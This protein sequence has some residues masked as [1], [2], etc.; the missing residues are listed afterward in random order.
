MGIGTI[1][2]IPVATDTFNKLWNVTVC[3]YEYNAKKSDFE[4]L[5]VRI[6]ATR[7]TTIEAEITPVS[8]LV[9][10]RNEQL[11]DLGN[12]LADISSAQKELEKDGMEE[13]S[14]SIS[15]A[16]GDLVN[17]LGS[18]AGKM[19]NV[20]SGSKGYY[21]VNRAQAAEAA[22]LI[23]TRMDKLNNDSQN[24]M[25]RLQSLVDKRD[26]SFETASSLMSSV[27]DTRG[28]AIKNMC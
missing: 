2:S 28:N 20:V 4:S 13:K 19:S 1:E 23:K 7:A 5:L 6:S 24:D 15:D 8:T 10:R 26:Q 27:S 25:T 14:V 12:A 11:A 21:T 9:R 17:R 22:E 18:E 16:T 3:D